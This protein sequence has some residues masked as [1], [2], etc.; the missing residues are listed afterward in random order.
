MKKWVVTLFICLSANSFSQTNISPQFS[1]LKGMEDQLGNTHL[2]YRIYNSY[3]NDPFYDTRNHIYHF[4]LENFSDSLF[5]SDY[6]HE[7]PAFV[8]FQNYS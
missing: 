3:S 1:E 7:D 5:L 8:I 4:D 2:F 6:A